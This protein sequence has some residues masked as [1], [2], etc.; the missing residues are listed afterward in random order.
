MKILKTLFGSGTDKARVQELLQQGA[1]VVDVRTPAEFQGGHVAGS[2]NIPLQQLE[3]RLDD[4]LDLE[5]PV[6]LCCASGMRSNSATTWL[7]QQGVTCVNGG[8]WTD[9]NA[10]V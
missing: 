8:S 5:A 6:V 7:Q 9:V 10:L 1:V 2:R 3:Q 4:I